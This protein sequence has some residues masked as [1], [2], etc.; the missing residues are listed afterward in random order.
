MIPA[1]RV[2]SGNIVYDVTVHNTQ[3]TQLIIASMLAA[4]KMSRFELRQLLS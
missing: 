1:G 2:I 4:A 3:L